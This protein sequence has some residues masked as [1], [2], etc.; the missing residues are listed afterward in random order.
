MQAYDKGV[1]LFAYGTILW[2]LFARE[3]PYEGIDPTD[4]SAKVV[5]GEPLQIKNVPKLVMNLVNEL[6]NL[7]ANKRPS[8]E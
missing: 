3:V 5:K 4:V 2:E 6:R 1:D 8:F 7:D